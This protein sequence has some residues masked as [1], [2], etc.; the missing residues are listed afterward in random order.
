VIAAAGVLEDGA[1]PP[2]SSRGP[3]NWDEVPFFE[4]YAANAPLQ[5]PDVA[6]CIGGFPVW[7]W[8][9]G[10]RGRR[11]EVAWQDDEG[12]GAWL[13]D[14]LNVVILPVLNVGW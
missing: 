11:V 14:N 7:H 12:I 5:K 4:D 2:F 9:T 13:R 1:A 8:A 3:C 10:P 6:A